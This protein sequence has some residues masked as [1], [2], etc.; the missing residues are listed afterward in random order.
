MAQRRPIAILTSA[1]LLPLVA[2]AVAACGGGSGAATA[3]TIPPKTASGQAATAGVAT[4]GSLGKILVDS[5][6]HT[7]YLFQP[8]TARMSKCSA[9]CALSWPPLHATG[10]PTAGA[11]LNASQLRTIA[12]SDGTQQV[13]YNG[14]PLYT[15]V[16]DQKPGQAT[17][18]GL[19]AFGG[20]W[21]ALSSVGT[22]VSK[23]AAAPAPSGASSPAIGY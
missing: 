8:D 1:L 22:R 21:F 18:Q 11:G 17:G 10:K 5:Q 4:V 15:F 14:H 23:A 3:A 6:G 2:L 7:L 12:R 20:S 16:K 13:T 9:A 19:S